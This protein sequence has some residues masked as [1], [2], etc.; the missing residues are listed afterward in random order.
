MGQEA[1]LQK[2]C[3]QLNMQLYAMLRYAI[4]NRNRYLL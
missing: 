3:I 1:D 2:H 4:T